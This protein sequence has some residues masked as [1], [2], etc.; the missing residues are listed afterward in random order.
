MP[1]GWSQAVLD[2]AEQ[3]DK[4]QKLETRKFCLNMRNFAVQVL[5]HQHRLLREV[6]DSLSLEI[7]KKHVD[8]VVCH[9]LWHSPS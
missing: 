4:R 9:V 6:A 1:R 8:T 5:E 2:D 7:F 3:W